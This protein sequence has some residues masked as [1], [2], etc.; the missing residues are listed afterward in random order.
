MEQAEASRDPMPDWQSIRVF[1]ALQRSGSFRS[2]ATKLGLSV[3]S[4]R[5]RIDD[6]E[7]LI[8]APLL[9]RHVDG[10][11]LT[12]EGHA[13]LE[14]AGRME[15]A[16]FSLVRTGE[17]APFAETGEVRIAVT[18]GLGAFWLAPR[19]VEF[20]RANPRLTV[21]LRCAME[22]ADVLRLEADVAI[23]LT[24]PT[25]PDLRIVKIGRI[26]MVP[27]AARSYEE[28]YGLP[29]RPE[30]LERHRIV[31]QD[32][33]QTVALE[34]YVRSVPGFPAK[35]PITLR[36]NVS[37]AYYWAI[38]KGAGIGLLPTYASAI[39]AQVV[40][41]DNLG[42]FSIDIWLTYHPDA[43]RIT[44]V[45]RT[46]DWLRASFDPKRYPWFRDEFIHPRDLP[47]TV[48]GEA[49]SDLFAGFIAMAP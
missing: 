34:D 17:G 37:S 41:V 29:A 9:T 23:Q 10:I 48:K 43:E 6:L 39:G 14:A 28:T 19:L 40:P 24:R 33:G 49:L 38:A 35:V 18:E 47:G 8:G 26:H 12:A 2:A 1:L 5:R 44:R 16:A 46:I 31:V 21:D 15:A 13:I 42:R 25:S 27:Y 22:S 32:G 20:Q 3:N 30:D 4:V 45:R 7:A 11:R 36:V